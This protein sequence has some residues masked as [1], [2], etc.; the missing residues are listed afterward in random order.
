MINL[1]F[2]HKFKKS[3]LKL[4]QDN[5]KKSNNN[6]SLS[7]KLIVLNKTPN[8]NKNNLNKTKTEIS[9]EETKEKLINEL[10]S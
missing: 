5:I 4:F 7:N 6:L 3:D 8:E 1:Q 9:L 2:C 10:N